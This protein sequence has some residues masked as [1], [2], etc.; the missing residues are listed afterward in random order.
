VP[1]F[2][3]AMQRHGNAGTRRGAGTALVRKPAGG[4]RRRVEVA[5]PTA[6][7]DHGRRRIA[8]R[9]WRAEVDDRVA[10]R[11][12]LPVPGASAPDHHLELH[13]RL[14]AVYVWSFEQADFNETHGRPS[15]WS[16]TP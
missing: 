1:G 2:G 5:H 9:D 12:P 13:G 6:H 15:I 8:L 11:L 3:A 7:R 16:G 14:E 4:A 10:A